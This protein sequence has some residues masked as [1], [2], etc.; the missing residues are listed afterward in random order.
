MDNPYGH[1][2]DSVMRSS[3]RNRVGKDPAKIANG[4]RYSLERHIRKIETCLGV[5]AWI[6][7]SN[8]TT[9]GLSPYMVVID[10][11]L[12][13]RKT[14]TQFLGTSSQHKAHLDQLHNCIYRARGREKFRQQKGLCALCNKPMSGFENTEIDHIKTRGAHGRDDRME[15]LRVVHTACHRKRHG[16]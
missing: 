15:N 3:T 7:G 14:F 11:R 13:S 6:T 16:G 4:S 12:D 5:A 1:D 10:D 2:R 9:D 8:D